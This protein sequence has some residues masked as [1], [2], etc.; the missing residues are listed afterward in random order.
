MVSSPCLCALLLS[1][2]LL[3][4][5]PISHFLSLLSFFSILHPHPWGF[6]YNERTDICKFT[7]IAFSLALSVSLSIFLFPFDEN[8]WKV[9]KEHTKLIVTYDRN[10]KGASNTLTKR[11]IQSKWVRVRKERIRDGKK[12]NCVW[13]S[14]RFVVETVCIAKIRENCYFFPPLSFLCAFLPL[15]FSP[16]STIIPLPLPFTALLF[17]L[18][19]RLLYLL[20]SLFARCTDVHFW[21]L[22]QFDHYAA[23]PIC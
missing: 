8:A 17:L 12:E 3:K 21:K 9:K 20:I 18:C 4:L 7:T 19:C 23:F 16:P 22:S 6:V 1:F 15:P 13:S 10:R 14:R 2:L 5:I 11:W